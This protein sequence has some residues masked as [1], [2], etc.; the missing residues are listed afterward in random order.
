M[1]FVSLFYFHL[2]LEVSELSLIIG[3]TID[4]DIN[5]AESISRKVAV[6]FSE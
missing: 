6:N 5:N 3:L 2:V 4:L 1:A